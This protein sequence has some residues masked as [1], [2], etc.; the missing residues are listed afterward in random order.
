MAK[1]ELDWAIERMN[2]SV[3]LAIIRILNSITKMVDASV[4]ETIKN[5]SPDSDSTK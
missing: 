4:A 3:D 5:F 2:K 1:T